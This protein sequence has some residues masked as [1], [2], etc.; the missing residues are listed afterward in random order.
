[1]KMISNRTMYVVDGKWLV[2]NHRFHSSILSAHCII[3]PI[4][5][6]GL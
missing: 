3:C 4:G 5:R 2:P 6:V 1:M